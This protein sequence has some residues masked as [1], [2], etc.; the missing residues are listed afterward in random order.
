[1]LNKIKQ[2]IKK[3]VLMILEWTEKTNIPAPVKATQE[4]L[5]RDIRVPIPAII[6]LIA[7]SLLIMISFELHLSFSEIIGYVIFLSMLM[8]FSVMYAV[9]FEKS[10]IADDE[11]MM[12]AGFLMVFIIFLSGALKTQNV[13]VWGM[14]VS[15]VAILLTIL[16]SPSI[17]LLFAIIVSIFLS[18]IFDFSI[19]SFS[20]SLLTS[21]VGI[22]A[23]GKASNR[24]DILKIVFYVTLVTLFFAAC[25]GLICQWNP[26]MYMRAAEWGLLNGLATIAIVAFSLPFLERFFSKTT[27][28]RILELGDFNQPLLKKFMTEAPGSYHHSLLVA[29]LS[30]AAAEVVGANPLLCRVGAYYHDVGKIAVPEYFIEN[31]ATMLSKRSELKLQMSSFVIISH[32]KEGVRL[33]KEYGIDKKIIDIIEQHHGT[34][35]VH[36]FFIKA[37]EKGLPESEKSLYR[38][39][40]PKPNT[41]ESAIIMLAD[42]VEATSRTLK[43]PT[44]KKLQEMVYKIINNKFTDGQLDD[45]ELTLA[46][47][48]KIAEKFANRLAS[49]YHAR[50]VYPEAPQQ[51]VL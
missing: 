38:Y 13:P 16:I 7:V 37:L 2:I 1:M 44:F 29:S 31:Q 48:H 27:M 10:F 40:G 50:I 43:E 19:W 4:A 26:A 30:E 20:F 5:K 47:L 24:Y 36:Y 42:A 21:I 39:P 49:I 32:V 35:L 41:K 33:A 17:A 22:F 6:A 46:D 14:P 23:A 25:T 3:P 11:G 45:V 18:V 28:I 15:S 12:L 34:S 9:R 8:L 51:Q